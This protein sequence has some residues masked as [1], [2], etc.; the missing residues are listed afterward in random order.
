VRLAVPQTWQFWILARFSGTLTHC[1]LP[2]T[3]YSV[4]NVSTLNTPI[5]R[6]VITNYCHSHNCHVVVMGSRKLKCTPLECPPQ[7]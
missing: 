1:T 4:Q 3:L 2:C 7:P 5:R 6:S